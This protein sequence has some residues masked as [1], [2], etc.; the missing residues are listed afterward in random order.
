MTTTSLFGSPC[1]YDRIPWW[2]KLGKTKGTNLIEPDKEIYRKWRSWVRA[3]YPQE[4][5]EASARGFGMCGPDT[6]EKNRVLGL[7]FRVAGISPTDFQHGFPR[8]VYWSSFYEN[9]NEFLCGEI[10]ARSLRLKY[11]F[12]CDFGAVMEWWQDRAIEHFQSL[13]EKGRVKEC[14]HFYDD[15]GEMDYP[16]AKAK[17]FA[18]VGR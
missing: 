18:E 8:G 12:E 9:T 7:I 10:T 17:Y 1:T 15:L 2:K 6:S 4:F 16:T 11:R 14:G 13:V 5:A 3:E